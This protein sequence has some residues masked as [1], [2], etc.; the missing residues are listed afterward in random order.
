MPSCVIE[1][2][3]TSE[4]CIHGLPKSHIGFLNQVQSPSFLNYFCAAFGIF[5]SCGYAPEAI[6]N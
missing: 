6:N 3:Q 1:I 5:M 2:A 4:C